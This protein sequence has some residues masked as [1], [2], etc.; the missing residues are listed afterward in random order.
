MMPGAAVHPQPSRLVAEQEALRRLAL[1]VADGVPAD[2]LFGAVVEEAGRLFGA[3]LAG[4]TRFAGDDT[5]RVVAAWTADGELPD[6][7][8]YWPVERDGVASELLRTTGPVRRDDW[9]GRAG[10]VARRVRG[11]GIRSTVASPITVDGRLWGGLLVHSRT[12]ILPE[13][14]ETQMADFAELAATAIGNIQARAD[15]RHLADEQ[16]ALRYVATLVAREVPPTEVFAAVAEAV[17]RL[18]DVTVCPLYRY[19]GDDHAVVMA[20][21]GDPKLLHPVGKRMPLDGD[22]LAARIRRGA[23]SARINDV[24]DATGPIGESA[25][26]LGVR[27]GV[28]T[29]IVVDGSLWGGIV[30]VSDRERPLPPDTEARV[31]QFTELVAAAIANTEAR[32]ELS[33]SRARLVAAAD[34]ERRRLI[35]DLHDGAQQRLVHTV[36]TIAMAEQAAHGNEKVHALL[37]EASTHA[38]R[39]TAELRELAH[40]ILPSALTRG[41]LRAG[42]DALASRMPVPTEQDVP[43][44]RF[45]PAV[46]ATAYFVIAE[47]LTNV[48][49]HAKAS[50]AVVSARADDGLLH[51]EVRD[52]GVGGAQPGGRGLIGLAD[53][54][55][56]VGG[57]LAIGNAAEGG[58]QISAGIPLA[59]VTPSPAAG[60]RP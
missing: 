34:D 52:D 27:S 16:A 25:R 24:A 43:S 30:V 15:A 58:T 36:V 44:Q 59:E 49:H 22:N 1:L 14:L 54:V 13:G 37:R 12:A 21:W 26:R 17:A 31:A 23:P 7:G 45:P 28:A 6:L 18:L 38:Q 39:A 33:A 4:M 60:S 55:A 9:E 29:P 32:A 53:R 19:E 46:E 10:A 50:R 11:L 51:V 2:E 5:V 56:A 40:G 42:V 48:A 3:D 35:R 8:E 41:G 57:W 47:A 20:A